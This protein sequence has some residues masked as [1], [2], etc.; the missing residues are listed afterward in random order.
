MLW[1][2][3]IM[4]MK[5]IKGYVASAVVRNFSTRIRI[6]GGK[7]GK[8]EAPVYS[9]SPDLVSFVHVIPAARARH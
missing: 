7:T 2:V 1:N 9:T 5:V 6:R 3:K 4:S 8:Q